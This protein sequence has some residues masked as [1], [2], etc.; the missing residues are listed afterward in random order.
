M[1]KRA[2]FTLIEV[3]ISIAL[4]GV[5]LPALYDS[6]MLLRESNEHLFSYVKKSHKESEAMKVFYLDI[7]HSDGNLTINHDEYDRICM[8]HTYNSLYGLYLAKVCWVVLKKEHSLVRVEGSN[9]HLPV[10]E[11]DAVAVDVVMKHIALFNVEWQKDKV[12]VVIQQKN[13]ELVTFMVQGIRKPKPKKKKKK[14]NNG[15]EPPPKEKGVLDL[16]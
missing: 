8:E 11:S 14:S 4:L 3:L 9:F 13:K 5:I 16:F 12:I 15:I 2:G 6:V 1:D 10:S 7:A